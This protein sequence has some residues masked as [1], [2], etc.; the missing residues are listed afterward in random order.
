[1]NIGVDV[2]VVDNANNSLDE[3]IHAFESQVI[4]FYQRNKG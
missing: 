4:V 2:V 1:M 3:F